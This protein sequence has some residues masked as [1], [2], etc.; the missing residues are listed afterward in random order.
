MYDGCLPAA[1]GTKNVKVS[2]VIS[3]DRNVTLPIAVVIILS[4]QVNAG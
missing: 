1:C 4:I 3:P 2:I